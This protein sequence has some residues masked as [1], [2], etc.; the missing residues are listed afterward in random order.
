MSFR[1]DNDAYE[2]WLAKLCKVVKK[3]SNI[4]TAG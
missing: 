2:V 3:T 1:D 4:N